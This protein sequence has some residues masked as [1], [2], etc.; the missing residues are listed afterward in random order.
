VSHADRVHLHGP[1]MP[2]LPHEALVHLVRSAPE[3]VME[4]IRRTLGVTAPINVRP[5]LTAGDITDLDLAEY[6]ADLVFTLGEPVAQVFI[7]EAQ[8]D[9]KKAKRRTWPMYGAG[10][11]ARWDCPVLLVVI[12]P[13]RRVAERARRPID[14]GFGRFVLH[15]FVIGPDEIPVITDVDEARRSPELAV[16]SV[17]AHGHDPGAEH[18]ALAA[19]TASRDLDSPRAMLYAD[20]CHALLGA[21]A[22]EALERIMDIGKYEYQSDF[23]RKYYFQGKNEGRAEGKAEALLALL[24]HKGLGLDAAT[25]ARVIACVDVGRID[26]WIARAFDATCVADVFADDAP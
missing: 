20:F 4:L 17:A 18:I 9:I 2:R 24:D 16:L 8:G 26:R 14:L 3:M 7:V 12:A 15:P 1:T 25:R 10:M 6:R 21:V 19:L 23:A 22:R 13:R 11:H 5:R